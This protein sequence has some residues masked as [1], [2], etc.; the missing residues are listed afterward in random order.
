MK[1]DNK[2][3]CNETDKLFPHLAEFPVFLATKSEIDKNLQKV[4]KNK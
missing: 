2:T 4:L 1:S 3:T